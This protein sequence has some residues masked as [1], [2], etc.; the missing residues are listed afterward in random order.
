MSLPSRAY[1]KKP[2][3][4]FC[5]FDSRVVMID[6]RVNRESHAMMKLR[7]VAKLGRI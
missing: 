5:V 2:T 1:W 6:N 3:C 7:C 4:K